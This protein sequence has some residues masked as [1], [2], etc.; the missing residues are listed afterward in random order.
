MSETGYAD[1][2]LHTTHS[3]GAETPGDVVSMAKRAGLSIVSITDHDTC[4]GLDS[5]SQTAQE[6]GMELVPG[7]EISTD[8]RGKSAHVLGYFIDINSEPLKKIVSC[9]KTGRL[10]RM[11]RIVSR[12]HKSGYTIDFDDLL[13]YAGSAT[14]GRAILARYLVST[15][16]FN[17]TNEVFEKCLG[18]D[19]PAFEPVPGLCPEEAIELVAASGGVSS[20]A[21]PSC[22]DVYR[23]IEIFVEAGL[24][25]IEVFSPHHC[26][27]LERKFELLSNNFDLLITGGSDFHGG[28]AG[29]DRIGSTRLRGSLVD[30]L[31][32]RASAMVTRVVD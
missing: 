27:E 32:E 18:D 21:H 24:N 9:N 30:R 14:L 28:S 2:H 16:Y 5:A 26:P 4:S 13:E 12:L 10:E 19:K 8:H 3:D 25:G 22:S 7:I 20:L 15:G 1:L 17:D 23:D 29:G 11:E 31:R 6:L